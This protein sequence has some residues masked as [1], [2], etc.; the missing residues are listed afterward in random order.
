MAEGWRL[1]GAV[2]DLTILTRADAPIVPAGT[3]ALVIAVKPA[4]WREAIAPL[5][6]TLPQTAVVVSVMAGIQSDDI[7]AVACRPIV[8][9]MP[10][11]AVAQ[12]QGV[13][14]IWS[15]DPTARAVAHALFDPV[16]DA[17]DLEDEGLIDA[18]TAVSGCAPAFF[19]ALAQALAVAGAEAGLSPETAV[20]LTRGALRSAG[21]GAVTETALDDLIDRIASPGG[22]TRAGLEALDPDLSTAARAAVSAAIA[23]S[24]A[25][26]G[27]KPT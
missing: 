10:T 20:R 9:V 26:A 4:T 25:L 14:A 2:S 23:K 18:A 6:A 1:T 3:T 16:S 7:A 19:Y 8:R 15:A 21:A 5:L 27:H 24:R 22:V 11:T 17:V 13:A 12:A